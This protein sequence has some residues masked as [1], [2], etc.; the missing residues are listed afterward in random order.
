MIDRI[1]YD[2]EDYKTDFIK[3]LD[4]EEESLFYNNYYRGINDWNGISEPVSKI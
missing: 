1:S 2:R 4:Q 3:E